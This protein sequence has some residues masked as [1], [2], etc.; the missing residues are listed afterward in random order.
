MACTFGG[1]ALGLRCVRTLVL[2]ISALVPLGWTQTASEPQPSAGELVRQAVGNEVAANNRSVNHMFRSH[3]Q[4]PKGS[5]TKLYIETK[6]CMAAML[7]AV[8]DQPVNEQQRQGET[9]HLN[10]LANN[11]E[12]QHKKR[13]REKEDADRTMRIVRALP[14]AF[15]Y[16][17]DGTENGDSKM[18]T[19]G[20]QL[21]RLKF[22]PNPSY[23]PP[24]RVEQILPGM[25][26]YVLIDPIAYRLAKIDGTL[27]REVSF[28]WG[29]LGH[30]DKGGHFVVKQADLGDGSWDITELRL[31]LTGKIL[32]FKSISMASDELF[33]D[34]QKVPSDLSFAQGVKM[35]E[36]QEEKSAHGGQSGETSEANRTPQ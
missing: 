32:M 14:D 27:F 2:L 1:R 16:E 4:T 24:T 12:Q 20:V 18:G 33:S 25:Q 31:N 30:L 7:I 34:F 3:K 29:I 6:D 26:G 21:V 10:W 11:P 28:G 23:S 19:E 36:T 5:Q 35:L 22:R 13:S 15:L 8:N 9:N 17:Y